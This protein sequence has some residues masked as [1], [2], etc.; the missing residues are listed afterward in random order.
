M[1]GSVRAD[2]QRQT[3][4]IHNGHDFRA[5]FAQSIGQARQRAAKY[6]IGAP[7]LKASTHCFIVRVVLRHHV[8]LRRCWYPQYCIKN[9]ARSNR[10]ATGT[11]IGN[12]FLRKALSP[13]PS[14]TRCSHAAWLEFGEGVGLF[15]FGLACL[16]A[17][18]TGFA[19]RR[20][21]GCFCF[22]C[23]SNHSVRVGWSRPRRFAVF[24]CGRLGPNSRTGQR[25]AL[26]LERRSDCPWRLLV[27]LRQPLADT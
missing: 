26:R 24:C 10:F 19:A 15:A 17:T 22:Q 13:R 6:F 16:S 21:I 20:R 27:S 5:L 1:V 14:P 18:A 11:I 7:L 3:M 12:T 4:A 8:P 2:S 25:I 23:C 9:F